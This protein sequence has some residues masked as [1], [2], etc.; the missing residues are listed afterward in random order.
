MLLKWRAWKVHLLLWLLWTSRA[1][2]WPTKQLL[3]LFAVFWF[4]HVIFPSAGQ[5][6]VLI[7]RPRRSGVAVW[8]FKQEMLGANSLRWWDR[9]SAAEDKHFCCC[10]C[11]GAAFQIP[12]GQQES[13]RVKDTPTFVCTSFCLV[14]H[15]LMFLK[16]RL[17]SSG[18][19]D[20]KTKGQR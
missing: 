7:R 18:N 19:P 8:P 2:V 9:P 13:G 11:F 10:S 15:R 20:L 12:S 6:S 16:G 3:S 1:L 5:R 4:L 17:D 14:S